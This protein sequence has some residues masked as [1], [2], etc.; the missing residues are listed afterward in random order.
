MRDSD[1]IIGA[2]ELTA[3]RIQR[4]RL[5]TIRSYI[6]TMN[7]L[8]EYILVFIRDLLTPIAVA[9]AI[10]FIFLNSTVRKRLVK[11]FFLSSDNESSS[12]DR[13]NAELEALRTELADLKTRVD[14]PL[15]SEAAKALKDKLDLE[16][17]SYVPDLVKKHLEGLSKNDDDVVRHFE[18]AA[19]AAAYNHLK[20]IPF[21]ELVSHAIYREAW[22]ERQKRVER[23][24]QVVEHQLASANSTRMVMMNLFVV[25]NLGLLLTFVLYSNL[26][27]DKVS[28][29]IFGVYVS[30][31]AFI[32][33]IYRASN[34]R[35]ASLLSVKEDEKKLFDVF[36]F[37]TTFKKGNTF[38]NNEVE[39]VRQLLINRL[40]RERGADHPYEVILKGVTN[41]NVLVRGGKVATTKA[42]KGEI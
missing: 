42:A 17:F 2:A 39:L 33:Y 9:T 38:T 14:R 13:S 26:I 31:S 36:L 16:L 19:E 22:D 11:S 21:T 7:Y 28:V 6:R 37:L 10:A 29:S 24:A 27:T 18:K 4:V 34:A 23:F 30:L 32:I 15:S 3:K 40:E 5:I 35:S 25:F 1:G 12:N 20:G 8:P 41:S